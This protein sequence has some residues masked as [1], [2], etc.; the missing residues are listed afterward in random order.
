LLI[1]A[2]SALVGGQ[3]EGHNYWSSLS[4]GC[5]RATGAADRGELRLKK[6]VV[7]ALRIISRKA[8]GASQRWRVVWLG[9]L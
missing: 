1:C 4:A 5:S 6:L 7:V 3:M 8:K 2:T 9:L